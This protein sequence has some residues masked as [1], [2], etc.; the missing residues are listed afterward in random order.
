MLTI[1]SVGALAGAALLVGL[2]GSA[3]QSQTLRIAM[4]ASDVPTVGGI[5]DNGSEG[6]R[7]RAIRSTTRW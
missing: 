7:L 5:P 2:L 6:Y 3:A 1:R 4:T